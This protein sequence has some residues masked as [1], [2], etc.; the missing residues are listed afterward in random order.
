MDDKIIKK[1]WEEFRSTGLLLMINQLL[2]FFGWPIMYEYDDDKLI[3]VVPI[4]TKYRGY[5]DE[6]I[7]DANKK[8]TNYMVDNIDDLKQTANE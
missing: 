6:S 4:R 8:F 7:M 5:S 1:S 3:G 2:Q